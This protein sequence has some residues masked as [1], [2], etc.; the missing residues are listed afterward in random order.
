M[1]FRQHSL[2]VCVGARLIIGEDVPGG[3]FV[4]V[5]LD[6]HGGGSRRGW[7]DVWDLGCFLCVESALFCLENASFLVVGGS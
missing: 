5:C 2:S 3:E 1:S 4:A 6:G 7:L